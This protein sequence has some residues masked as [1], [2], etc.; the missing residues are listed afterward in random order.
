MGIGTEVLE[1]Q[2]GVQPAYTHWVLRVSDYTDDVVA[3]TGAAPVCQGFPQFA[4]SSSAV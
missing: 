2:D 4:D 1:L 3:L